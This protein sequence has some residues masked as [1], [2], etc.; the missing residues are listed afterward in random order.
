MTSLNTHMWL[1]WAKVETAIP[2]S[3]NY[4]QLQL[5]SALER[6]LPTEIVSHTLYNTATI[7][8][9]ADDD[10]ASSAVL[11]PGLKNTLYFTDRQTCLIIVKQTE[12]RSELW[13]VFPYNVSRV[14][15]WEGSQDS[16]VKIV[17]S[18]HSGGSRNW[19]SILGCHG[20]LSPVT[21]VLALKTSVLPS[22]EYR[23]LVPRMQN[24]RSFKLTRLGLGG[25]TT[26]LPRVASRR[27][28]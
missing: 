5:G 12:Y 28:T 26:P 22:N 9:T 7:P 10:A 16:S 2:A 13:T 8:C 23:E 14:R 18:L 1:I 6:V 15:R 3:L 25:S 21:S 20:F 17:T 27:T 24:G 11:S 19:S 4:R